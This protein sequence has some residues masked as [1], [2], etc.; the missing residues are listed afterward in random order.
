MGGSGLSQ[1]G[2]AQKLRQGNGLADAEFARGQA[3][4]GVGD[5]VPLASVT[6]VR[7]GDLPKRIAG[8]DGVGV[9]GSGEAG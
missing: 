1:S 8:L 9:A 2:W 4:V 5:L 3:G 7:R 6:V